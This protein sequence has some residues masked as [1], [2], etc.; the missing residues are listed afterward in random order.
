[1]GGDVLVRIV[2]PVVVV[3]CMTVVGL[4]LTL[5]DF[6]RVTR[7]PRLV[8]VGVLGPVLGLPP[9]A[10]ALG[11]A[12][13]LPPAVAEGMVL[14]AA[15]PTA[16]LSNLYT[17]LARATVGLSVTVTAVASVASVVTL[18]LVL[19][20]GLG[21]AFGA[22]G[23]RVPLGRTMPQLVVLLLIPVALGMA[24][25]TRWPRQAQRWVA[26]L[27]TLSLAAVLAV[28][29]TI[30]VQER[31]RFVD[32]LGTVVVAAAAFTT[33]AM[34]TGWLAAGVAGAGR[35]ERF[36][37][38]MTWSARNLGVA[39]VVGVTILGR[40]ELVVFTAA[41][42]VAHTALATA[43]VGAYRLTGGARRAAPAA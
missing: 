18:P 4:D 32:I 31:G 36:A 42:F 16:V 40:A 29:A 24:T 14:V 28:V 25:R 10:V 39:T 8:G 21:P 23:I 3:F 11:H 41:F 27:R 20:F 13:A 43:A 35:A 33:A 5:E 15:C 1:M 7:H 17:A 2:I 22:G 38:A 37:V 34:A 12:L 19:T 26:P 30:V 6:R 9:L